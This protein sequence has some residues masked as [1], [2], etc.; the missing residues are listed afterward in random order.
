MKCSICNRYKVSDESSYLSHII[1][2]HKDYP[3]VV[4]MSGLDYPFKCQLCNRKINHQLHHLMHYNEFH[5]NDYA[6]LLR[7]FGFDLILANFIKTLIPSHPHWTEELI[8]RECWDWSRNQQEIVFMPKSRILDKEFE[9][10]TN[11]YTILSSDNSYMPTFKDIVTS[12]S[13][14][15]YSVLD[16]NDNIKYMLFGHSNGIMFIDG[17]SF[18]NIA[19]SIYYLSQR[20]CELYCLGNQ[21]EKVFKKTGINIQ[22]KQF[23]SE[24]FTARE[25]LA[26]IS[27][28]SVSSS[29]IASLLNIK[30]DYFDSNSMTIYQALS[31]MV[32][33][34]LIQIYLNNYE[35]FTSKYQDTN[36]T[37]NYQPIRSKSAPIS[38]NNDTASYIE[39]QNHGYD[40]FNGYVSM[41]NNNYQNPINRVTSAPIAQAMNNVVYNNPGYS[42]NQQQNQFQNIHQ[43]FDMQNKQPA[44]VGIPGVPIA[45]LNFLQ[46]PTHLEQNYIG[47]EQINELGSNTDDLESESRRKNIPMPPLTY[48][49]SAHLEVVSPIPDLFYYIP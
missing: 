48:V 19:S 39:D 8:H 1:S 6:N 12:P 2:I 14:F 36:E 13:I 43:S 24:I 35:F 4:A 20:N 45:K 21:T 33:P 11:V 23:P 26:F 16:F 5:K 15:I 41:N 28:I 22:F 40:Q 37:L 29:F 46:N 10:S 32:Y 30:A 27:H 44:I 38:I 47:N 17:S 18:Q 7:K 25:Y 31:L 34:V 3:A 42:L 9:F 49:C